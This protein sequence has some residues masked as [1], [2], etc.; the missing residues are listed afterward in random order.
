MKLKDLPDNICALPFA[1]VHFRSTGKIGPCCDFD[2]KY[3]F[4]GFDTKAY[5]QSETLNETKEKFLKGEWPAGCMAC[6]VQEKRTGH[7]RRL[8]ETPNF[9]GHLREHVLEPYMLTGF[10]KLFYLNLGLNNKCNLGCIMCGPSNSSFILQEMNE[11]TAHFL[12]PNAS[13]INEI[14]DNPVFENVYNNKMSIQ[15]IDDLID[16]IDID[17]IT[18]RI[19]FHGGEPSIMK[20]PYDILTRIKERNLQDKVDVSFN[21]NFKQYN[22]LWFKTIS[23]FRG[24]ALISLDAIGKQGEYIRW[25]SEWNI[26]E[27]NILKFKENYG[28]Q[29]RITICPTI[30]ILNVMHLN[31]LSKWCLKHNIE[32]TLNSILQWP[33]ILSIS[34]LPKKIK[35]NLLKE[36][37]T[38]EYNMGFKRDERPNIVKCLEQS[39]VADIS[40]TIK[41]LERIDKIRN[42]NWK[43]CFPYLSEIYE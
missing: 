18:T 20:E 1:G 9:L 10:K 32:L 19:T 43:E 7:S 2:E 24:H 12:N 25:P 23:E 8:Q 38:L 28:H 22:D 4:K 30:Q 6:K 16:L 35:N 27:N 42:T 17:N 26:V 31:S 11:N 40:D 33:N 34:N 36:I 14:I 21:S 3:M 13:P 29:Y 41:F 37:K 5:L 15:Q 39:P